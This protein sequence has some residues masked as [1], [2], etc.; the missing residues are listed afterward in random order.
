MNFQGD[1]DTNLYIGSMDNS[2][3]STQ[4]S[5]FDDITYFT[6]TEEIHLSTLAESNSKRSCGG[7][8]TVE[9][10]LLIISA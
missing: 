3:F 2:Q 4:L 6:S 9:E 5:N 8:F 7:N 1:G 10:D